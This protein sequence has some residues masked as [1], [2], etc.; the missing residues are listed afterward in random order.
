MSGSGDSTAIVWDFDPEAV[1]K[2]REK[3]NESDAQKK[4][5]NKSKKSFLQ[6]LFK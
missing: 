3:M 1:R 4:P 5:I 2:V 6:K